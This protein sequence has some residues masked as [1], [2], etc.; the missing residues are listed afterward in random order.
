MTMFNTLDN[1]MDTKLLNGCLHRLPCGY[2]IP[3]GREC[4]KQTAYAV[5]LASSSDSTSRATFSKPED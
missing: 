3:L 1:T 5:N 2:C 4:P